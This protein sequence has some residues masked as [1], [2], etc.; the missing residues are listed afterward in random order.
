MIKKISVYCIVLIA[1]WGCEKEIT[2]SLDQNQ[3]MLVID[4]AITDE[5][6]P[7]YVKLTN[8]VAVSDNSKF[9]VVANATVIMKDNLGL[10]DTLKYMKDGIYSTKKLKGVYGNT[11]FLEVL[12]DGKKYTAQSTMPEKVMFDSLA[13]N[14]LT[15]FSETQ[16]SVIP[17]YTDPITFGNNYRFVQIIND[18][19]DKTYNIFNDDLFNGNTIQIALNSDPDSL[20]IKLNDIVSVEMQC[21]SSSTYLYYNTLR[22]IRGAGPGGGTTPSNPPSNIVG[23]ALGLFSAHTVQ[24]K[25]IQIK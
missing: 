17:I 24:R 8:S 21:I 1:L 18:T 6:G 3:S 9:P 4:A 12:L 11:Y 25:K 15:I 19:I 7:Y 16:Y 10:S 13:I 2:L 14:Y 22:Q 23:G 5:A 20:Q